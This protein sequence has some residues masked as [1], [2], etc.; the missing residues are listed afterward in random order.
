MV[1]GCGGLQSPIGAPGA[2]PQNGRSATQSSVDLV[3]VTNLHEVRVYT[4]QHARYLYSLKGFGSAAGAC[5]DKAGDVFITDVGNDQ[6]LEYAHGGK[7]PIVRLEG[8][9][10]DPFGCSVDPTTGN[11][12]VASLGPGS[13]FSNGNVA[14]YPKA[15]GTPKIYTDSNFNVYFF[16]AYDDKGNLYIDGRN[17]GSEF[18][19]AELPKG[20]GKFMNV[21]LKHNIGFPASLQWDGK[22]VAVGDENS[23]TIYKFAI[24][25]S[26]GMLKGAAHLVGAKQVVAWWIH[27]STVIVSDDGN[28][29]LGYWPYP[30]GGGAIRLITKNLSFPR[31]ATVSNA[32][33]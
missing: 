22:Y 27:R 15:R 33:R 23:N 11:L 21:T 3:Y 13:S 4:Y 10:I 12:A 1:A 29:T 18:E 2:I 30:A 6:I 7:T 20:K 25:G 17:L 9:S 14:V 26:L 24:S 19:F 5:A 16:C 28:N 8:T 31:G 32:P